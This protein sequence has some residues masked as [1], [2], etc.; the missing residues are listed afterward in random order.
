MRL[1]AEAW[2]YE[3]VDE[4]HDWAYVDSRLKT[5][6]SSWHSLLIGELVDY[7]QTFSDGRQTFSEKKPAWLDHPDDPKSLADFFVW[8]TFLILQTVWRWFHH[9][10]KVWRLFFE[11]RKVWQTFRQDIH[12][13]DGP[14][15]FFFLQFS[16]HPGSRDTFDHFRLPDFLLSKVRLQTSVT[17]HVS[18]TQLYPGMPVP[19]YLTILVWQTFL[20]SPDGL[21]TF[22]FSPDGLEMS[23]T[24]HMSVT[25]KVWQTFVFSQ[26]VWRS[27]VTVH[28]SVTWK[29]G[30]LFWFSRRSGDVGYNSRVRY[31][32]VGYSSRVRYLKVWQTFVFF[33]DSLQTFVFFSVGLQ[34]SV[35]SF[36][37]V[38]LITTTQTLQAG[39]P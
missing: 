38:F 14:G 30:R 9:R 3:L 20:F 2:W 26:T 8:Q 25:R 16:G 27:S 24:D 12:N 21:Q 31:A 11:T 18:V 32:D 13:S 5:C 39:S 28:V 15:P 19:G 17:V 10:P 7:L 1:T 35:V 4:T 22:V 23:V 36:V 37:R 33:S 34:T 29:S 6:T